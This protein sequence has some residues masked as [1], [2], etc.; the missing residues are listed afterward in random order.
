MK[1]FVQ[2]GENIAV[3]APAAVTS[4][5]GVLIGALFGVANGDADTGADCGETVAD[6]C[7]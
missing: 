6:Q 7:Q 5:A 2:R 4:G 3:P 1:N